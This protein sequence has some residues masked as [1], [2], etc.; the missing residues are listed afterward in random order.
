[1]ELPG[2]DDVYVLVH[3]DHLKRV[4]V[5]D[6]DVF[7]K[8][9][10]FQQAF[11]T[12]LLSTEGTQWRRQR[13]ILQPLFYQDQIAEY[14]DRMVD[15]TQR[16]IDRWSHNKTRDIEVE[17]QN[18]TLEILFGTL[19]GQD[20]SPGEGTELRTAADNLN[21]WFTPTSWMLP[22]WMWTPARHRFGKAVT[23]LREEVQLLLTE[24]SGSITSESEAESR[25]LLS[26]LLA[27]VEDEDTPQLDTQEI[28]DQLITMI[29]AGYET[30]AAALAFS[31]HSLAVH[32]DISHRFHKELDTVLGDKQPSL[33]DVPNLKLTNQIVTEALRLY[34]PIHT[35]PRRTKT[36]VEIDGYRIPQA[37]EVHLSVIG[38]HRDRRFYD[39]PYEFQP[40]R[41]SEEFESKLHDFAYV[42]FGGGRRTC[43]GR[44][45]ALLEAKLVLATIGQRFRFEHKENKDIALEPQIT[46]QIEGG[47]PMTIHER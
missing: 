38:V 21:E 16:R 37:K 30:T 15:C 29:F 41:W 6:V 8:T 19:L 22:Q 45:F 17:M 34:P 28:E 33:T 31:L 35:I 10:D 2:V 40:E 11:G 36:G 18:L 27:A 43:I 44:E 47:L 12:G 1:M 9:E 4:L 14:S 32:P 25:N 23:R 24:S 39:H 46:T 5:S 7:G 26:A 13:E 3:P 20:L 42:P